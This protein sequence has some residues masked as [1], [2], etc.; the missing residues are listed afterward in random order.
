MAAKVE[1]YVY[2]TLEELKGAIGL[3][4]IPFSL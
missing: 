2:K 3:N 4:Q 1:F